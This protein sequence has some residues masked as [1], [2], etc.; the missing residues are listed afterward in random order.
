M[1]KR[2]ISWEIKK[3]G[4]KFTMSEK[5][6]KIYVVQY[7]AQFNYGLQLW[8]ISRRFHKNMQEVIF[9]MYV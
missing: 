1:D 7:W 8:F 6:H 2:E 5:T 9:A 4:E 3:T